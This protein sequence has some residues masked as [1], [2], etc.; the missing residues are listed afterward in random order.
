MFTR[1]VQGPTASARRP[2][3]RNRFRAAF[4]AT[5]AYLA[6]CRQ[7]RHVPSDFRLPILLIFHVGAECARAKGISND[8]LFSGKVSKMARTENESSCTE[9]TFIVF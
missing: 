5:R 6:S 2:L 4:T 8:I 9:N 3:H 1:P 7:T